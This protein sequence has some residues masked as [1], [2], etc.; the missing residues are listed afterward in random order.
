MN[1]KCLNKIFWNKKIKC[2][3]KIQKIY[4]VEDYKLMIYCWQLKVMY[5]LRIKY[6]GFCMVRVRI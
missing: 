1:F 6:L 3:I 5:I 2:L 4:K